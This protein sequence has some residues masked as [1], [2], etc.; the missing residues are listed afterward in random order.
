MPRQNLPQQ[1]VEEIDV[2]MAIAYRRRH[3]DENHADQQ[4]AQS[5]ST[6]RNR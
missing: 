3:A 4:V 1:A 2:N 5:R 6:P